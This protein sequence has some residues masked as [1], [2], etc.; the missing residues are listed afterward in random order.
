[1]RHLQGSVELTKFRTQLRSIVTLTIDTLLSLSTWNDRTSLVSTRFKF[2]L[3]V[4]TR[5]VW[6]IFVQYSNWFPVYIYSTR[7]NSVNPCEIGRVSINVWTLYWTVDIHINRD[8]YIVVFMLKVPH[9][10]RSDNILQNY[11]CVINITWF[12]LN[13]RIPCL[14]VKVVGLFSSE[15]RPGFKISWWF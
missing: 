5:T 11:S 6:Y 7:T 4:R 12:Y 9:W 1:M 13:I 10:L 8:G 2:V 3:W 15:W 14:S